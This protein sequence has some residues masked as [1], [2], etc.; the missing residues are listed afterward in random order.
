M[1]E[2]VSE[3]SR[4]Q[5]KRSA[6]P[7]ANRHRERLSRAFLKIEKEIISNIFVITLFIFFTAKPSFA[8]I[9]QILLEPTIS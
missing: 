6:R 1:G 9:C 4:G 8:Y 7:T 5:H 2:M 3:A